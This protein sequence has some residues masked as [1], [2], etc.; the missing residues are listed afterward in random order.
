MTLSA[1]IKK[2]NFLEIVEGVRQRGKRMTSEPINGVTAAHTQTNPRY[3]YAVQFLGKRWIGLLL[4]VLMQGPQR[5]SE[6][7]EI[8][9]G[10]SDRV[11]SERLREL[12]TEGI[13]QRVVY[14]QMP[15]RIEY[16][17]TEKGY[18]LQPVLEAIHVWAEQ[19]V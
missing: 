13:V 9:E 6:L 19:W 18:A 8:V 10:L 2:G 4:D 14:P 7:T 17:L 16:Q 11:L 1:I 3:I 5:F 15:T 12:E